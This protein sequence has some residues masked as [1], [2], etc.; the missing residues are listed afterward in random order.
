MSLQLMRSAWRGDTLT[1]PELATET[2][3]PFASVLTLAFGAAGFTAGG[4]ATLYTA[5]HS[6]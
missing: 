1:P 5:L 3:R 2:V 6:V 4:T